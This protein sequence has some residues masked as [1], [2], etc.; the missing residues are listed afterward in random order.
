MS[1][2]KPSVCGRSTSSRSCSMRRQLCM[3]PQQISPS[4]ASRS[5]WPSATSQA[6]RKV[7]AIRR[8]LPSGPLA[9]SAGLAAES[10]RTIPWGRAAS[11]R[12]LRAIRQALR[13]CATKR[14]RSSALPMAEPPPV[15]GHT[16]ATTDPTTRPS[17]RTS[18]AKRA[19]SSS[20]ESMETCGSNRKRSTPSNFAP[21]APSALSRWA[22][23]VRRSMVSRP[24][25]GSESGPLPTRPGHMALWTRG[26]LWCESGAR[27]MRHISTRGSGALEQFVPGHFAL[28]LIRQASEQ[29]RER[30]F[31][32][33]GGHAVRLAFHDAG[34]ERFDRVDGDLA[35]RFGLLDQAAVAQVVRILQGRIHDWSVPAV[36][37]AGR[38]EHSFRAEELLLHVAI[39]G[40]VLDA[41]QPAF[42]AVGI[43]VNDIVMVGIPVAVDDLIPDSAAPHS[44]HRMRGGEPVQHVYAV[45]ILLHNAAAGVLHPE[46]PEAQ[47][48]VPG[49]IRRLET[50]HGPV[51]QN[52]VTHHGGELA[53]LARAQDLL[54]GQVLGTEALLEAELNGLRRFGLF[55]GAQHALDARHIGARRLLAVDM[56]AEIGRAHV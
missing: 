54:G 6:S 35:L 42:V 55:G 46:S 14:C 19:R 51:A 5:P 28:G 3:P 17:A 24:M 44:L 8:V 33:A 48:R 40:G 32:R 11:S 7:C 53:D 9:H 18:S 21:S 37:R 41:Q 49:R 20:L 47:F 30:G 26:K 16:G 15:G 34:E 56:L 50:G 36:I 10:M 39:P 31:R 4:A 1:A 22:A 52:P 2:W 13:T 25:G 12:S 43:G 29:A 45:A 23:A 38:L 27:M